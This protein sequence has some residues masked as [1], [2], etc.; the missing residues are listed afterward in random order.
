MG[1]FQLLDRQSHVLGRD[2]GALGA[3]FRKHHQELLASVAIHRVCSA[4]IRGDALRNLLERVITRRVTVVV[5]ELL[6][7]VHIHECDRIG[8]LVATRPAFQAIQLVIHGAAIAD[9]QQ[10]IHP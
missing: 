10:R 3:D 7:V 2:R 5:I 1:D 9:A 4:N 6:E 8:A